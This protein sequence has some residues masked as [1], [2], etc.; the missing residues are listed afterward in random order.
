MTDK[1][2]GNRAPRSPNKTPEELEDEM[3]RVREREER[4]LITAADNAGYFDIRLKNEQIV[5]MVRDTIETLNPKRSALAKLGDRKAQ[6][7]NK[8][9]KDDARRKVLLGGFLVAQCRHK[10]EF[11]TAIV[12]DIRTFLKEN[13]SE[14]VAARNIQLLEAFLT[15]PASHG[16]SPDQKDENSS[17]MQEHRR[18]R[19]HRL[20]LLGAWVMERR[21]T[22]ADLAK[23]IADELEAFLDQGKHA[24]HHKL[25]IKDVLS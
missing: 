19:V 18:V 20:I 2:T 16:T 11:H 3:A 8:K 22:R 24:E 6:A 14:T 25:L 9:R 23:L 10:R 15:D 5:K 4:R 17:A 1:P 13:R 7:S 12:E 21:N